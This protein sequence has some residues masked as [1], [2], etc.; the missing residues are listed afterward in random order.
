MAE[1]EDPPLLT[2][3]SI[4]I[5]PQLSL[6][7][8]NVFIYLHL[9]LVVA[10]GIF[11]CG[12]WDLVPRPRI[13]P[14]PPALG[15]LAIGPPGKSLVSALRFCFLPFHPTSLAAISFRI[16]Y[17]STYLLKCGISLHST[18]PG[19]LGGSFQSEVGLPVLRT[20]ELRIPDVQTQDIKV[21]VEER[22]RH[23]QLRPEFTVQLGAS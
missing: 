23:H 4:L 1:G 7:K 10:R 11:S 6:K 5:W 9:V 8:I 3:G 19:F 18:P 14:E 21:K 12:M 20:S 2:S 17:F 22:G 15:I 13:E 16:S